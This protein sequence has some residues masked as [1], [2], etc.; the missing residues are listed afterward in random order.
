MD[1]TVNGETASVPD[2]ASVADVVE[3]TL[4]LTGAPAG[5]AGTAV[6]L[7]DAVVPGGAWATTRVAPGA[8]VE[9]LRAVAGG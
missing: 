5:G 9:V 1:I 7:D 3:A 8:R 2:A 6:A 4:T